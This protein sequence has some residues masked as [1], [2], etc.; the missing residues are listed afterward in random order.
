ML[1]CHGVWRKLTFLPLSLLLLGWLVYVIGFVLLVTRTSSG[2]GEGGGARFEHLPHYLATGGPPLLVVLAG[3][4]TI[5]SGVPSSVLG[6]VSAL[7][8]VVCLSSVG[9][10]LYTSALVLY[11][12][13][14]F[15]EGGSEVDVKSILMFAGTLLVAL[16]WTAVL[17]C[18]NYFPYKRPWGGNPDGFGDSDY[19]VSEDGNMDSPS[20]SSLPSYPPPF[21]GVARKVAAVLLLLEAGSWCMLV[22]GIDDQVHANSSAYR[23]HPP[24]ELPLPFSTWTVCVVGILLIISATM[25]AGA[26]KSA[27]TLVGA[28]TGL[29]SVL[30][31]L[32]TGYLVLGLGI[33][34]HHSPH[35]PHRYEWYQLC[36][37]LGTCVLWGCVMA[38]WPFY[39]KSA[40]EDVREM[41]RHAERRRG[42]LLHARECERAPLLYQP[43]GERE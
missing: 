4:H 41:R 34:L 14:H 29:L 26:C 19:V 30:Y 17:M 18:W 27:G 32:C 43:N 31:L 39:H 11:Q 16:S 40:T 42:Y 15:R 10:A 13:L 6:S 28:F 3:L 8:S 12:Y 36:G 38:L 23:S 1:L 37:G 22:T 33:R 24:S 25:H 5:L 20:S 35:P 21:A 9:Y 7:W 2:E